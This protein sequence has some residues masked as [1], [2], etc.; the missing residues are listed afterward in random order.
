MLRVYLM[1]L[2]IIGLLVYMAV[3]YC[4]PTGLISYLHC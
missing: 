4:P 3:A 2:A 1:I